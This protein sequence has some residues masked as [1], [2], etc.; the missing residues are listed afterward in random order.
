[1]EQIDYVLHP[2]TMEEL[3]CK[4]LDRKAHLFWEITAIDAKVNELL[5]ALSSSGDAANKLVMTGDS[6]DER[7]FFAVKKREQENDLK[8]ELS[9]VD[10]LFMMYKLRKRI[11]KAKTDC[12]AYNNVKQY[13]HNFGDF[14]FYKSM[15][16][17]S[18]Y[19][20]NLAKERNKELILQASKTAMEYFL[21]VLLL[22][23]S[24]IRYY[25]IVKN[26]QR[27]YQLK[28]VHGFQCSPF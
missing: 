11:I 8:P 14:V 15:N 17:R 4:C 27:T 25:L 13:T 28:T 16:F 19:L 6:K 9:F 7:T 1:M 20:E 2:K 10:S 18:S 24:T 23:Y 3:L 26:V 22:Q 21:K 5:D 12:K